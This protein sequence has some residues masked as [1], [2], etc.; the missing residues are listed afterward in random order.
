[1]QLK[2]KFHFNFLLQRKKYSTKI[3]WTAAME[4]A[5]EK[6]KY[7][8]S[9]TT[10]LV[11]IADVSNT[12]IG[13]TPNQIKEGK[14]EPLAFFYKKLTHKRYSTYDRELLATHYYTILCIYVRRNK[15]QNTDPK[16]LI[17][18]FRQKK[19]LSPR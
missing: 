1:M 4:E 18:E 5:F 19:S 6:C 15:F 12:S 3:Q 13:G 11:I 7:Y 9:K 14:F 2:F 8:I 10:R 16:S 17:F